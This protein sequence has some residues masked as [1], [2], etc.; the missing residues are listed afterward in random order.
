M[1]LSELWFSLG[2]RSG[3]GLLGHTVVLFLVFKGN[4]IL[5]STIVVGC[6]NLHSHQTVQEGFLFSIPSAAFIICR[7]FDD[8]HYDWCEV[9]SYCS[10]DLHFCNNKQC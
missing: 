7:L 1:Y 2:I 9:I 5:F 3:V 4:F 6:V 10:F 8:G